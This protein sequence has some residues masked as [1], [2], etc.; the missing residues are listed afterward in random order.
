MLLDPLTACA[1][2]LA[3]DDGD[4]NLTAPSANLAPNIGLAG[5]VLGC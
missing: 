5:R 1:D 3:N 4:V 2:M